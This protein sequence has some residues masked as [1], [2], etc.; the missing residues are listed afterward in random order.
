MSKKLREGHV[1]LQFRIKALT[2]LYPVVEEFK[3]K[4]LTAE[5]PFEESDIDPTFEGAD[6]VP[7]VIGKRTF[8]QFSNVH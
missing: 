2:A 3:A 4:H 6:V 8:T 1:N 5:E 7:A